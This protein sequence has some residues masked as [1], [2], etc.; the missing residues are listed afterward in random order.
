MKARVRH[1]KVARTAT[2]CRLT[3]VLPDWN[4]WTNTWHWLV[5]E[6]SRISSSSS[7]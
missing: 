1:S 5:R 4:I 3:K 6:C 2:R 7:S